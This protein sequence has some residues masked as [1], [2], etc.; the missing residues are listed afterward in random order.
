MD[1]YGLQKKDIYPSEQVAMNQNEDWLPKKVN[2]A[3]W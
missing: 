1:D 2:W 3:H